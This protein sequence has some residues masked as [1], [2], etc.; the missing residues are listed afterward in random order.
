[1]SLY[2]P[3]VYHHPTVFLFRIA[4]AYET[5]KRVEE[6][7]RIV[8]VLELSKWSPYLG[9]LMISMASKGHF[10]TQIP[11]PIHSSSEMD[12]IFEEGATSMQ[13]FPVRTTW[14]QTIVCHKTFW[15]KQ[16]SPIRGWSV[17]WTLYVSVCTVCFLDRW[18]QIKCRVTFETSFWHSFLC[19]FKWYPQFCFPW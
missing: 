18:P 10:L 5:K 6:I 2:N 3:K 7:V 16:F 8:I 19:P 14:E 1:M 4:V 13:S 15:T 12:A 11:Q 17:L 9:K